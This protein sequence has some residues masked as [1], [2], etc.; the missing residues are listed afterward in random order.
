MKFPEYFNNSNFKTIKGDYATCVEYF[1]QFDF[2]EDIQL[3]SNTLFY[4]YV[5]EGEIKLHSPNDMIFI[6]KDNSAVVNINPYIMSE[7]LSENNKFKAFILF[8]P[9]EII[10]EFY[11][12]KS[13]RNEF[14]DTK[15]ETKDILVIDKCFFLKTFIDSIS[16]LYQGNY[17]SRKNTC[18]IDIKAKELMYYLSYNN[19]ADDIYEM[20]N[21]SITK[22]SLFKNTITNNYLKNLKITELAFLCNMSLSSFKRKF[23]EIYDSPPSKWIKDKK[24]DYALR[25]LK[26]NDVKVKEVAY[27]CGFDKPST[28]SSLFKAKHGVLPRT[29]IQKHK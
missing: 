8:L 16:F 27:R 9:P 17:K 29:F 11:L 21:P 18:L 15:P 10:E 26:T 2:I 28:F 5:I 23:F 24:L 6:R 3:N 19:L 14:S 13:I 7:S 4:V 1:H 22:D 20:I 12:N 25:L